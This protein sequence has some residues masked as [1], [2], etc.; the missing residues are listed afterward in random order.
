MSVRQAEEVIAR[1]QALDLPRNER[2]EGRPAVVSGKTLRT[3][4][5]RGGIA[6]TLLSPRP[7]EMDRLASFWEKSLRGAQEP[8][9][10]DTEEPSQRAEE[11]SV[12][13]VSAPQDEPWK[14]RLEE[15]LVALGFVPAP[16]G[17]RAQIAIVLVSPDAF[18][19]D[20][21]Q[22]D[23][24]ALIKGAAASQ[25]VLTWILLRPAAWDNT[26]LSKY[27]ALGNVKKPLAELPDDKA[28]QELWKIAKQ[29]ADLTPVRKAKPSSSSRRERAATGGPI[30]VERLAE[31]PFLAD[32]SVVNNA[33]IAFLAEH[34]GKS[35]LVCGD[36][37]ADVL[38]ESIQ[39]LLRKRGKKRLRVD[40][41]VVPR[42]GSERNLHR[43]LL[44]L[45]D[46][47]RYLFASNGERYGRP[48]RETI[49]RILAFGRIDRRVSLTLVFNYRT[50]TTAV[51]DDLELQRRWNYRTIYPQHEGGG[52][53]VQI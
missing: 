31:Q 20:L 36:A 12:Y 8:S 40:A 37:S 4:E 7:Q 23:I 26:A 30:D 10:V 32:R 45:L 44:E 33:S 41:V 38:A 18:A 35:L 24:S 27:Q 14:E 42:G 2:W 11:R 34:H 13:V 22:E 48:H 19:S 15:E 43:P 47:D 39:A 52:I 1:L 51:W 3:I 28:T 29:I 46:S 5:L 25:L 53:K 6:L 21:V 17:D 9:D 16:T 49:A 50:P